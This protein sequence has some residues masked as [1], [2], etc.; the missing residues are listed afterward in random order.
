M[1]ERGNRASD[2]PARR[3]LR[4]RQSRNRRSHGDFGEIQSFH[5]DHALITI[6]ALDQAAGATDFNFDEAQVARAMMEN[7]DDLIVVADAS[8]FQRRAAFTVCPLERIGALVTDR[9]P[10]E[11]LAAALAA[12]DVAV[13]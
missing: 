1:A 5:A 8:K 7:A 12:A 6:G 13:H 4:R 2:V 10:P 11:D 3:T 9:A